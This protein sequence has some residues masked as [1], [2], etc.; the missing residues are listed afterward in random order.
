MSLHDQ[1]NNAVDSAAGSARST[2]NGVSDAVAN[3]Q[4]QGERF[5]KSVARQTSDLAGQVTSTLRSAGVDTDRIA[6]KARGQVADLQSVLV[7]TIRNRPVGSLAVA[8]AV[9]LVI[10]LMSA[11]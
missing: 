6:D 3:A 1:A 4:G 7:E 5:A 11:R 2:I 10:G 9:G 8:A